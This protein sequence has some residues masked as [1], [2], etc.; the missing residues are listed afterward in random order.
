[1]NRSF[2]CLLALVVSLAAMSEVSAQSVEQMRNRLGVRSLD[3]TKVRVVEDRSTQDAVTAVEGGKQGG[4]IWGYRVVIFYDDAQYA[5]DRANAILEEFRKEYPEINSYVVYERPHFKVSVG[6]CLT[7]EEALILR[8]RVIDRYSGAFTRRDSITLDA[9]RNVRRRVDCYQFAPEVRDS[10]LYHRTF[11]DNMRMDETMYTIMQRD[12]AL[13]HILMLD[14]I[15]RE[16]ENSI[17]P[18]QDPDWITEW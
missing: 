4:S 14:D 16:H 1:M 3:G 6:D 5:Q 13:C 12:S 11:R 10:L 15:N 18:M 2:L 9:L 17:R 7:D 8:N